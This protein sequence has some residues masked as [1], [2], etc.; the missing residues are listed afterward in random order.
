MPS[1][2]SLEI[3]KVISHTFRLL[4]IQ[5]VAYTEARLFTVNN[6][7]TF[8]NSSG[9]ISQAEGMLKKSVS[10]QKAAKRTRTVLLE[11]TNSIAKCRFGIIFFNLNF[12]VFKFGKQTALIRVWSESDP[13]WQSEC[14]KH[15]CTFVELQRETCPFG[16]VALFKTKFW[17]KNCSENCV[18]CVWS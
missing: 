6:V 18:W 7:F 3:V 9:A 1:R 16:I 11:N 4:A 10:L 8:V 2:R 13:Y 14:S 17:N 12:S 5:C 15:F